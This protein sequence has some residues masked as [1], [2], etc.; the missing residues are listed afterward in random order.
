MSL[1]SLIHVCFCVQF[2]EVDD[3]VRFS[4]KKTFVQS[5]TEATASH[6]LPGGRGDLWPGWQ[7]PKLC[8]WH[9]YPSVPLPVSS[10]SLLCPGWCLQTALSPSLAISNL[11][12][13]LNK[14][15]NE[16]SALCVSAAVKFTQSTVCPDSRV[17]CLRCSYTCLY[18][19][20][21]ITL[22]TV[23]K[24]PPCSR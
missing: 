2:R 6:P 19:I 20:S 13:L 12:I 5:C 1:L 16:N 18:I 22:T 8:R 17:I 4:N 9:L 14:E 23:I 10:G 7:A 11:F 21:A 3:M 15:T 24:Q